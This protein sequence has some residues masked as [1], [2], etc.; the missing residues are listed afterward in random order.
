MQAPLVS[1][2]VRSTARSTLGAAL[3]SIIAQDYPHLEVVVIAA[4]GPAHPPLRDRPPHV[5]L[6]TQDRALTRPDAAEAGVR[7]A[8]GEAITFLDDDDLFMPGHVGGLVAMRQ[9]A[10]HARLDYSLALAR[11]R[12]GHVER[13]GQPYSLA[14]LY[15]RNFIHLSCALFDRRLVEE[16]AHFDGAFEIMQDW[17]FFLQCAQRTPFHFEPRCTFEWHPDLGSSG[18]GGGANTDTARFAA[19]RDRLY[20]KWRPAREA[21][22]AVVT[23]GLREAVAHA[24]RGD[25]PAAAQ[26]CRDILQRS[27]NDPWA[28]NF[29]AAVQRKAGNLAQARDTQ[30]LAVAV[31]PQDADLVY[32]LA[33]LWRDLGNAAAAA[34]CA[35]RALALDP[36]HARARA[37]ARALG[38]G[39]PVSA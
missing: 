36:A 19:F 4:S 14:Q 8:R 20:A 7:A 5:R 2:I 33:L 37:L 9:A 23:A 18:T 25:L 32:N 16:G 34:Q 27:P 13:W 17:D 30:A 26:R 39:G 11:F 38:Q 31:R 29:L 22:F 21:L 6:V 24:Q 35:A 3:D 1:V 10:P 28:L 15:E 12:D